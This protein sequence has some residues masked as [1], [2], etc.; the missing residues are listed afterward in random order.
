MIVPTVL[1]VAPKNE[2]P[3]RQLTRDT[4]VVAAG[5]TGLITPAGNRGPGGSSR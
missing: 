4:A 1:L 3:A 2:T 5:D